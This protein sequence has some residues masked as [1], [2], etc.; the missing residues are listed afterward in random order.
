MTQSTIEHARILRAL[1]DD[2][3]LS[4]QES[5]R[6]VVIRRAGAAPS[7]DSF[8]SN[9]LSKYPRSVIIGVSVLMVLV[10][11]GAALPSLFRL[12]TAGRNY[13]LDGI[14]DPVQAAFVG[15]ATFML[16]EFLIILST[17]AARVFFT[18]RGQLIFIVPVL[19]GLGM[20]LVGNWVVQ[21][22]DDL[23]GW[24]ET[25]APPLAVLFM[26]LVGERLILESIAA[27]YEN[28]RAYQAALA[29]WRN[30]T[31]DPE[32]SPHWKAAYANAIKAAITTANSSGTGMTARREL[33]NSMSAADWRPLLLRELHADRWADGI[34][35]AQ[36]ATPPAPIPLPTGGI[37]TPPPHFFQNATGD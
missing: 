37:I 16:S 11:I 36:E 30:R 13:F 19:L 8:A 23:F 7:R 15:L 34:D 35:A 32:A 12:F 17:I 14:N 27:R 20:A 29:D 18:G 9:T 28:E 4:A 2:E 1:T 26:A 25:I 33:I 21:Q 31:A 22:P 24:L 3:R 10:F 6:A 5:A